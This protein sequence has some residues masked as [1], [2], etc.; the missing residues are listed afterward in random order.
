MYEERYSL[1][2]DA[3]GGGV[4]RVDVRWKALK[5]IIMDFSINVSLME[6][7]KAFEVYRIDTKHGHLHEHKFWRSKGSV[8]L[9]G[10]YNA[11]FVQK[12]DDAIGNCIEWAWL[13][14]RRWKSE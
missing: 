6:A 12:K 10:D 14:K 13:L 7:G 9:E 3:K 2:Q 5:G 4:V 8:R 11:V 1:I